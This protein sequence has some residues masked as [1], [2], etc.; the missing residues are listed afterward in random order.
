MA[1]KLL[2]QGLLKRVAKAAGR[3]EDL[4]F[5]REKVARTAARRHL[6]REA[7]LA[8]VAHEYGVT[9]GRYIAGLSPELREEARQAI[10]IVT[11]RPPSHSSGAKRYTK[12]TT[13]TTP[14]TKHKQGGRFVGIW[15]KIRENSLVSVIIAAVVFVISGI[16]SGIGEWLFRIFAGQ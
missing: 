9:I 15:Q 13:P 1:R 11:S 4:Q 14:T 5:V 10:N 2:D 6:S 16:L 3:E 8:L 7:A 12:R